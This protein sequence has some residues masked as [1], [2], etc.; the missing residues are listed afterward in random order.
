[1]T[2]IYV[3]P[4]LRC[5]FGV[6]SDVFVCVNV[7]ECVCG[8]VRETFSSFKR[9]CA[10][11]FSANVLVCRGNKTTFFPAFYFERRR[12]DSLVES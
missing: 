12:C 8:G 4:W 6:G 5:L 7:S 1:M 10:I 9:L 3:A 11:P 2:C